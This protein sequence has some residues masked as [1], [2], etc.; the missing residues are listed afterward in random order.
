MGWVEEKITNYNATAASLTPLWNGLRD[1]IGGAVTD[2]KALVSQPGISHSDC[3]AR[4]K[5]CVRVQKPGRFIEVFLSEE[6][7]SIRSAAGGTNLNGI[8]EDG[9]VLEVSR[10][11][12]T[13]DRS[14]LEFWM[15]GDNGVFAVA[16]ADDVAKKALEEFLFNPFP[17]AYI[18]P[19]K[20]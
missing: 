8:A 13:G 15:A 3:R 18:R 17:V 4:G 9:T 14:G 12:L 19:E 6:D 2:F 20:V 11:R 7:H 10:Y 16:S 1:S 5:M